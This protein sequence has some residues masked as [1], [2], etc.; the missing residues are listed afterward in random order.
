MIIN[1]LRKS[2]I[3]LL[4]ALLASFASFAK[5]GSIHYTIQ[6]PEPHTHYVEVEMVIDNISQNF[7]EIKMPVWAPGSYKVREFASNTEAISAYDVK[8]NKLDVQIKN[9]NTWL[10]NSQGKSKVVFKYRVYAYT[11]SVRTSFVNADHA[12]LN[13][14]SIFMYEES[15]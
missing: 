11:L 8:G 6:F 15:M 10:V 1:N 12:Y 7:L 14:T 4:I 5:N 9:K 2:I 3:L 13:G